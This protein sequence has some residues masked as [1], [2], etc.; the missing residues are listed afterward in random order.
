M[1]QEHNFQILSQQTSVLKFEITNKLNNLVQQ[2]LT[3]SQP[4][5]SVQLQPPSFILHRIHI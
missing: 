3:L 2:P 5:I 1:I 4:E